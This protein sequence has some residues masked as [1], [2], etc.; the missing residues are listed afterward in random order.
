MTDFAI[1][2]Y[3]IFSSGVS[4]A[5]ATEQFRF[6]A[7]HLPEYRIAFVCYFFQPLDSRLCSHFV[8]LYFSVV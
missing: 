3:F 4:R 7:S 2:R 1:N 8:R 5:E 6:T